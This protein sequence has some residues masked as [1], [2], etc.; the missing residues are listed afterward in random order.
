MIS[1]QPALRVAVLR[2]YDTPAQWGKDMIDSWR[3]GIQAIKPGAEVVVFHPI[4][5]GV[6]P[7]ADEFDLIILTGGI[8]NLTLPDLD[9]W[10]AKTL[11]FVR[12][13]AS[14]P[15]GPKMAGICWGHQ[16]ICRA[17]GGTI[18]WNTQGDVVGVQ[19][20]RCTPAGVKFFGLDKA[21]SS[22]DTVALHK[23]HKRSIATSA[24]G[25]IALAEDN[26]IFLSPNNR[27]ITFQGHPEMTNLVARGIL[28]ADDGAYTGAATEQQVKNIAKIELVKRR[29]SAF[30]NYKYDPTLVSDP[31]KELL[32]SLFKNADIR[33]A[34]E[35][36]LEYFTEDA[37]IWRNDKVSNGSAEIKQMIEDSWI[38]VSSRSHR[39]AKIFAFGSAA[40]EF[41]VD[42]TTLY[43]WEDGTSKTGVWACRITLRNVNGRPK[44]SDYH[45][46]FV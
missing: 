1:R 33:T 44:I 7:E 25:F 6:F 39:P 2:N 40:A 45:V 16:A 23:F 11:D 13:T 21:G 9:P 34:K 4:T 41:M 27:T 17:M 46:V 29:R 14:L 3:S 43:N 5:D 8:F 31:V 15:S 24:P 42:G 30:L 36:W 32:D 20:F 12:D 35:T 28:D 38:N 10:V 22:S 19:R 18:G 26:E 37:K